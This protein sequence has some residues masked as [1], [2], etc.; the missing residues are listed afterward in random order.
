MIFDHIDNGALYYA[1]NPLFPK[2][3]EYLT[4]H[5][6]TTMENGVYEV[7]EKN[8]FA[9]V[10]SYH[11]E[12]AEQRFWE[13]HQKYIDIQ[14]VIKGTENMA[15]APVQLAKI[16]EPYND[17]KDFIKYEAQGQ[18]TTVPSGYFTIFY[19]SDVHM[20]NLVFEQVEEV[21][22]VVMKVRVPEPLI[23]LSFASNNAHK[24]EE[25][26]HQLL[27][28]PIE[29]KSLEESGIHEELP[30]TG[31][32]LEANAFEKANR[33]Y[34]KFGLHCFADDTG[35]EV[36]A[37]QGA[38]GVYSARYAGI[39]A[40]YQDNVTRLLDEMKG[41]THRQARFRTVISLVMDATEFRFEGTVEGEITESPRGTN[42]FGYDSVFVPAG[43]TQTFAE[44]EAG[45]KNKISH[46]AIAIKKLVK[47]LK[48]NISN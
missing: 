8:I 36:K 3:F 23:S 28:S 1:L 37:L 13:G 2:A 46:R 14:L 25:V 39:G 7:D 47:F 48:D 11:T 6:F 12:P 32:T 18:Q 17:E 29:V 40:S 34:S 5:D 27:G 44:M 35:L 33:V 43:Y 4:A 42:G 15:H 10:N 31:D 38:P 16:L 21:K 9:I 20:P 26:R 41:K 24:L 22:K 19:P 45:L 30:E